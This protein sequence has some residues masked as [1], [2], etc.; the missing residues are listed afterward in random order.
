MAGFEDPSNQ[1]ISSWLS[2]LSLDQYTKSFTDF[3]ITK[4]LLK[5]LTNFDLQKE[6]NINNIKHCSLIYS[7]IHSTQFSSPL[8]Q[9]SYIHNSEKKTF[10]LNFSGFFL[11]SGPNSDFQIPGAEDK[12]CFISFE[13]SS[14]QFLIVHNNTG[15]SYM[16]LSRYTVL[17]QGKIFCIG[18]TEIKV[19]RFWFNQLGK[20][21]LCELNIN[22]RKIRVGKGGI[23][24]GKSRNC[25]FVLGEK[26]GV[27]GLHAVI[28]DEFVLESFHCCF[29]LLQEGLM[30]PMLI[31][32]VLRVGEVELEFE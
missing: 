25:G 29:E 11:G 20:K 27:H 5:K 4:N 7:S 28:G 15:K 10:P 13:P 1:N 22:G 31:G 17:E 3:K 2:N 18:E 19:E 24:F 14:Q 32:S 8:M 30:Y 16:K 12:Q 9:L 6:L 26:K 23:S 21:I